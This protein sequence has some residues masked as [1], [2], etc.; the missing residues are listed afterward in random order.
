VT[1]KDAT[2]GAEIYYMM[3][4]ATTWSL[5]TAP[6]KVSATTTL[7]AMAVILAKGNSTAVAATYTIKP[8][9]KAAVEI[10]SAF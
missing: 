3:N 1:L 4:G 2:A 5:Y 9:A 6:L 10:S 8:A 7:R